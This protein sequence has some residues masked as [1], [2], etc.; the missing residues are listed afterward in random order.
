M[1]SWQAGT[2]GAAFILGVLVQATVVAYNPNYVPQR[3]QTTLFVWGDAVIQVLMNTV[4]VSQLPRMQKWMMIPHGLGWIPVVILLW[5]KVPH[6]NAKDVITSFTSNGGWEPIGLSVMV[7][8]VTTVY[9]LI[10]KSAASF[11]EPI[12]TGPSI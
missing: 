7:G 9:F 5:V 2:A 6:A 12:L 3:W 10:R 8:Q 4:G 11:R 1:L